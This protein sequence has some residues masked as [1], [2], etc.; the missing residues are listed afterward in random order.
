MRK[1]ATPKIVGNKEFTRGYV[2]EM[3]TDNSVVLVKYSGRKDQIKTDD[4]AIYD[5]DELLQL[6]MSGELVKKIR[7]DTNGVQF[8]VREELKGFF[9]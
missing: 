8:V 1:Y 7:Q 3:N 2:L 5:N 6:K 4:I 9:S